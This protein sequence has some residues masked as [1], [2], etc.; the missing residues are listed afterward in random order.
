MSHGLEMQN[1]ACERSGRRLFSSL[2]RSVLPGQLLRVQ[3]DNGAGKTSLL[4]MICG[5]M[6]PA[7]GQ[8]LWNGKR[9]I[10]LKEELGRELIYL[11]H[12]AALKDDLSAL[13]NL[14]AAC[15]LAGYS[16]MEAQAR[17]A[18]MAAGLRGHEHTP[19]CKLSQGQRKRSALARLALGQ[20]APNNNA[21]PDS[22]PNMPA[23]MPPTIPL[24]VL[25]EPFNS[26]DGTATA[27]LVGLIKTQLQQGGLVV[28][29]SHQ[30]VALDEMPHQVLAL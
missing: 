23:N 3:G 22:A 7:A 30:I 19:V 6:E 17:R 2:S 20:A 26:L 25:D 28:L 4:R 24:W 12:A 10:D 15:T 13:E 11:G 9:T 5:L 27:W 14:Q 1:V 16:V 18:L 21:P 29:T 8:L